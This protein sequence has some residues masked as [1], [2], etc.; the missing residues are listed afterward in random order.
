MIQGVSV[1]TPSGETSLSDGV[2]AFLYAHEGTG[3]QPRHDII[4][5]GP[6]E[7]GETYL[8]YRLD[9]REINLVFYLTGS[10][11]E[12][13]AKRRALVGL[14]HPD[15]ASTLRFLTTNGTRDIDVQFKG[16]G[17]VPTT[18]R[19]PQ[20]EYVR[21]K[22]GA[23][24][25]FYDPSGVNVPFAQVAGGAGFAVPIVVPFSFGGSTVNQVQVV[26]ES[27]NPDF[28]RAEPIIT[29][30]G[31]ITDPIITNRLTGDKLDFTGTTIAGGTTYTIDTRYNKKTVVDQAGTNQ[32]SKLA[33]GSSIATFDIR[34][35][36]NSISV[37]GTSATA[38]TLINFQY[39]GQFLAI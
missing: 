33:A 31:P 15:Y 18:E 6:S 35:G 12:R 17:T 29:I 8:D 1:L 3:M 20:L 9:P 4:Q 22:F 10:N 21:M 26:D 25:P 11:A 5:R 23:R 19:W 37:V 2:T 13:T 7:H 28:F 34:R 14:F 36:Q 24:K 39:K 38:A 16:D 27:A 30:T 32:I